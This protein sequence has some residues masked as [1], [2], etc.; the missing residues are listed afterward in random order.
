MFI[1]ATSYGNDEH[2]IVIMLVKTVPIQH[3]NGK[4]GVVVGGQSFL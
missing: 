2:G 4:G 1:G 3:E